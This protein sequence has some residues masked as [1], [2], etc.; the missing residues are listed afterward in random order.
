MFERT[1]ANAAGIA[2]MIHD[3]QEV[4]SYYFGMTHKKDCRVW[5]LRAQIPAEPQNV[6]DVGD[7]QGGKQGWCV[8]EITSNT[9]PEAEKVNQVIRLRV[10][11]FHWQPN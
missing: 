11:Q 2:T 10:S 1:L 8:V 4:L 6:E 3:I 5:R 9:G 7:R